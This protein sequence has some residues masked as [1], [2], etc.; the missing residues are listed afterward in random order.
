MIDV[1]L[2]K[3]LSAGILVGL[4]CGMI[5]VFIFLLNIPFVGVAMAHAAM[6]GGIWGIIFNIP[7][8][9]SAFC[10]SLIS[11]FLIGPMTDKLKINPNITI[12]IIFSAVM[13]FAFLGIGILKGNNEMVLNFLWGNILLIDFFDIILL[14]GTLILEIAIIVIFYKSYLAI[15]FNREIAISLGINDKILY[16]LIFFL[17]GIIIS[18]NLD[19][20]GGLM[21]FSLIIT[22]PAIAYHITFELKKFFILSGIFGAIGTAGGIILSF[23]L[24]LPVSASVV[25]FMTL[26]FIITTVFSPKRKKYG[27]S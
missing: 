12:S 19:I 27:Q 25:L 13:G 14:L 6:A 9:L 23:L 18:I 8:K 21:L 10:L 22:P 7:T 2:F 16:Y 4:E 17:I 20:I 15:M 26:L 5:G 11:S 24:N 1:F 3:T